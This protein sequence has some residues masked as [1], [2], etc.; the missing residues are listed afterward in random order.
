MHA[1]PDLH[2]RTISISTTSGCSWGIVCKA[3]SPVSQAEIQANPGKE[4]ISLL[5][6]SRTSGWSSTKATL[7]GRFEEITSER[8]FF[9]GLVAL[10]PG[11][12]MVQ[13]IHLCDMTS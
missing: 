12:I 13:R 4:L 9:I 3:S 7:T 2:G 11:G 5:Q 8:P 6:L 1:M 10:T